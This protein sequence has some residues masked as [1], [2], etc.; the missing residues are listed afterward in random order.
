MQDF[1]NPNEDLTTGSTDPTLDPGIPTKTPSKLNERSFLVMMATA[2]TIGSGISILLSLVLLFSF[3]GIT[4]GLMAAYVVDNQG[5]RL[6]VNQIDDPKRKQQHIQD[7][8]TW[9]TRSLYTYRWYL[10]NEDGSKKPD[11]GFLLGRS[12]KK[13]PTAVYL[14][15]LG[16]EPHFAAEFLKIL[17]DQLAASGIPASSRVESEFIPQKASVPEPVGTG[18]WRLRVTGVQKTR[19]EIGDERLIPTIIETIVQEV[20]AVSQT[21]A[22]KDYPEKGVAEALADARSWGLEGIFVKN[23]IAIKREQ[24]R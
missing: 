21:F 16:L 7:Y 14:G 9:L 24:K 10:P 18:K 4:K 22:E 20:P 15:S 17:A 12:G 1:Y 23:L 19:S 11:P 13:V 8:A 6:R 5:N 2:A 3:S